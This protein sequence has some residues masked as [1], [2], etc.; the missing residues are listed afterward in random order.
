MLSQR[1]R[2]RTP[3]IFSPKGPRKLGLIYQPTGLLP[4]R[5]ALI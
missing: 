4:F 1:L 3:E 2:R 5:K